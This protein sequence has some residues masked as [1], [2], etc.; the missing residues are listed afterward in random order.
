MELAGSFGGLPIENKTG[1]DI[2]M[3]GL[4]KYIQMLQEEENSSQ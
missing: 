1:K 4:M 3:D 2:D